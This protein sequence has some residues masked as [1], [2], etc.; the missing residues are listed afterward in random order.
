MGDAMSPG[1]QPRRGHLIQQ[2]LE[3]VV[4][5]AVDQRDA[6]RRAG[7]APGRGQAGKSAADDDDV[8]QVGVGHDVYS[9]R[10]A[11]TGSSDAARRAGQ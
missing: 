8:R 4:V 1:R 2:R 11:S 7:Q 9:Y 3:H 10:R 6:A 5:V